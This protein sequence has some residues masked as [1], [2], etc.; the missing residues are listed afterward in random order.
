GTDS[1]GIFVGTQL[2]TGALLPGSFQ[3]FIWLVDAP[4]EEP[5]TYY[6]TTDHAEEGIGDVAECNEE[7]NVGLTETVA[8][9]IAG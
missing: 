1:S 4:A 3:Q 7:N 8:C 6:A 2:T 9:P 5:K